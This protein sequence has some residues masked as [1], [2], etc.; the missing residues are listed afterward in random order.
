MNN[1][2]QYVLLFSSLLNILRAYV[3]DGSCHQYS[4]SNLVPPED[5]TA[6]IRAAMIEAEAMGI[7]ASAAL[8]QEL[9]GNR[10]FW[11]NS[12]S[13]LFEGVDLHTVNGTDN[14]SLTHL[15]LTAEFMKDRYNFMLQNTAWA[16]GTAGVEIYCGDGNFVPWEEENQ[17]MDMT[18]LN[19]FWG[20]EHKND[21]K[22]GMCTANVV[23]TL[24]D[25]KHLWTPS[26]SQTDFHILLLCDK[27]LTAGLAGDTSTGSKSSLTQMNDM[28]EL[29]LGKSIDDVAYAGLLS[30]TILHELFHVTQFDVC[31]HAIPSSRL[32][33]ALLTIINSFERYH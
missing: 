32:L 29:Y 23:A 33:L 15:L 7:S 16:E 10:D 1:L 21:A 31:K 12:V 27:A 17:W 14:T 30:F 25:S 28:G 5:K 26:E 18:S 6:M 13:L 4:S 2:W 9:S 24:F 3:I 19:I 20:P 8:L 22:A 11:D